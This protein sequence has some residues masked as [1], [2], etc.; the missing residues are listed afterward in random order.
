VAP[1]LALAAWVALALGT[2]PPATGECPLLSTDVT[3]RLAGLSSAIQVRVQAVRGGAQVQLADL[4]GR[5]L[6]DGLVRGEGCPA[7]A[8]L[9]AQR[10]R[11]WA[12]AH[13]AWREAGALPPPPMV[14]A[15]EG[16]PLVWTAPYAPRA[17]ST[18]SR[19]EAP[20]ELPLRIG[21]GA[22]AGV[23]VDS[24]GTAPSFDAW[25]LLGPP[26]LPYWGELSVQ[27]T[28]GRLLDVD[29]FLFSWDRGFVLAAGG[30]Y[31]LARAPLEVVAGLQAGRLDATPVGL[32]GPVDAEG[33]SSFD[34][35][36][37]AGLRALLELGVVSGWLGTRLTAWFVQHRIEVVGPGGVNTGTL[38]F[39]GIW[40]GFGLL[41]GSQS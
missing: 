37:Y 14:D 11:Q 41:A 34:G 36:V 22:G 20:W 8:D 25:V 39:L 2:S 29:R 23:L 24:E 4:D 1:A 7:L 35:G 21:G 15:P 38:P 32:V 28:P 12:R 31:R 26:R 3:Q 6:D 16:G 13:G 10:V 17:P 33:F 19:A 9:A 27:L 40:F 30:A 5:V 18:P